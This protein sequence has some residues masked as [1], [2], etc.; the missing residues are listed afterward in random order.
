M[1]VALKMNT[2]KQYKGFEYIPTCTCIIITVEFS[3][4]QNELG[5]VSRGEVSFSPLL[6][7][8]DDF[9]DFPPWSSSQICSEAVASTFQ[10]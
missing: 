4:R 6:S 3:L 9:E 8:D 1:K 7:S 5:V 2:T 10:G